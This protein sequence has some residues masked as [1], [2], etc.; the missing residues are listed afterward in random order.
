[1]RLLVNEKGLGPV[2]QILE[3]VLL[4]CSEQGSYVSVIW[5]PAYWME[6]RT[7]LREILILLCRLIQKAISAMP[8]QKPIPG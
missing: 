1:M 6:A 5:P 4:G 3:F 8:T 2:R 7:C